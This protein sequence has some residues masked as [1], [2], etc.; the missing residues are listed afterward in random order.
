LRSRLV[1]HRAFLYPLQPSAL[2]GKPLI[3]FR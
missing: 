2:S 3:F 1:Q